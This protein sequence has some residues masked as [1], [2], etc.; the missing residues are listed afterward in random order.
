[1]EEFVEIMAT[2]VRK[3]IV[4][5]VNS[6]QN[7][8]VSVDSTPDLSHVDQL[9]V[10]IRYVN[11]KYEAV[12]RFPT[13]MQIDKSHIVQNLADS[14]ISYLTT[15]AIDITNCRGQSY[16]NASN[17]SGR[18]SGM[19]A[20]LKAVNPLAS[21]VPCTAHSLNFSWYKCCSVLCC[22]HQLFGLVQQLYKFWSASIRRWSVLCENLGASAF[23]IK[24][25]SDTRWCARADAVK[26]L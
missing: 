18:Y 7:Y 1:V 22:R 17:M 25:L 2:E 16:D 21:F 20:K 13:F 4:A 24:S 12:E 5:E 26:A 10:I 19:Q 6:A 23:T 3:I 8:S 9:T 14:L 11:K 15:E